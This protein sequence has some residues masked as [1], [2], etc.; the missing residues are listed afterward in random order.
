MFMSP[1]C[2]CYISGYFLTLKGLVEEAQLELDET[3]PFIGGLKGEPLPAN[4]EIT[5]AISADYYFTVFGSHQAFIGGN[6]R[7]TDGFTMTFD[8]G[9][10]A[11]GVTVAPPFPNFKTDAYDVVDLHAGLEIDR[12]AIM[13]YAAN[14]GDSDTYQTTFSDTVSPGNALATVLRPRTVGINLRV[15]F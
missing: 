13:L 11:S 9:T 1:L 6:W 5:A 2:M 12:Y 10:D 14:V 15:N 8:G 3:E 4:P 7:H